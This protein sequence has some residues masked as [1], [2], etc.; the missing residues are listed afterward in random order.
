MSKPPIVVFDLDGTL[1]ETAGDLIATLN[2]VMAREGLPGVPLE[3][4]RDLI[5]AGARALIER[6][7]ATA[8]RALP[9][10]KLDA[11]FAFFLKH[12]EENILVHSHLFEGVE[13][14]LD[15]LARQGFALAVCTNKMERHALKLL[16]LLG[17][18]GRFA[19]IAGKD[20]FAFCKPDPRHLTETIQ[21][22][23]GDPARAVMVGDSKTDIDTAKAAGIPVIGVP[24][25]YTSVPMHELGADRLVSHFRDLPAAVGD[26]LRM[27]A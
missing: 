24:F 16:D 1:A 26:L 22:A 21:L 4:A 10:A 13:D 27:P 15:Q 5:G 19:A 14:A 12:Y 8:G 25:G 18:R 6:G 23:G 2:A 17:V 3:K 7:F 9:P 20:T 11:L